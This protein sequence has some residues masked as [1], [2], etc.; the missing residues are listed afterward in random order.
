MTLPCH[1]QPERCNHTRAAPIAWYIPAE[2]GN[3]SQI[4]KNDSLNR[5]IRLNPGNPDGV[6]LIFDNII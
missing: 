4:S 3:N 2:E 6:L 1:P 5:P